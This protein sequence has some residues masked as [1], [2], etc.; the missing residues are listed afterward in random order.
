M[1]KDKEERK[2][3]KS[4]GS[5]KVVQDTKWVRNLGAA[6]KETFAY[7]DLTCLMSSHSKKLCSD[8]NQSGMKK[9]RIS[10]I[11]EN[12]VKNISNEETK[13]MI[14]EFRNNDMGLI[15]NKEE[16]QHLPSHQVHELQ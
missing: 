15:G 6:P 14:K 16:L 1:H 13:N 11:F 9:I 10:K 12:V 2:I 3:S 4:L 7:L 8:Q 5:W